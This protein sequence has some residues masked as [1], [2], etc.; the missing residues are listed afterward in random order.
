ME[1]VADEAMGKLLA[2]FPWL[3]RASEA[4]GVSGVD[5]P[6]SAGSVPGAA[7]TAK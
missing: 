3:N 1:T 6:V 7:D 2:S 4:D 5:A